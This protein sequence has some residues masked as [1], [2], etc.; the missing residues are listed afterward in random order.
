[1]SDI[2]SKYQRFFSVVSDSLGIDPL[3]DRLVPL[4]QAIKVYSIHEIVQ[5]ERASPDLISINEYGSDE[6]WWMILAYNGV[7]SYTAITEGRTI[8]IPDYASLLDIVTRNAVRP[9]RVQRVIT[10]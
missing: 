9:N 5:E 6:F 2:A 10:I 8:K 1:M 4:I 7:G 3:I